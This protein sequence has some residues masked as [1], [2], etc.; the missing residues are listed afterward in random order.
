M[1]KTLSIIILFF[2]FGCGYTSIYSNKT[3]YDFKI[4]DL[5]LNGDLYINNIIQNELIRY[6][7]NKSEKEY[8]IKISSSFTKS[9]IAKD[10]T[11]NATDLSL[12]VVVDAEIMNVS[13]NK[14]KTIYLSESFDAV[15]KQNNYEQL[16][17]E[18]I[19]KKDLAKI[20]LQKLIFQI[21]K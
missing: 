13:N 12:V 9:I 8:K 5:N 10:K 6:A 16:N 14:V 19:I 4:I 21:N 17:Y 7:T 1:K 11:G 20:V 18:K 15:K 2:L 3:N